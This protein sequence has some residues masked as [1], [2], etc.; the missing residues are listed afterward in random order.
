MVRGHFSETLLF[1]AALSAHCTAGLQSTW[2]VARWK[3]RDSTRLDGKRPFELQFEDAF[4]LAG[5]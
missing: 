4:L 1:L 3:A 5:N 2:R